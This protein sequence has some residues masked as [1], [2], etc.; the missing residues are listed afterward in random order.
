MNTNM[1]KKYKID[2]EIS[3]IEVDERYYTFNYKVYI[4]GKLK[5]KGER[6][7]DYENGDSPKEWKIRLKAGIALDEV[8]ISVFE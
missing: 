6:N 5:K 8:M 2:V 4:N 7:S 3:N 1:E